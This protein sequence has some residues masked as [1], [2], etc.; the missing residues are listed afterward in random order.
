MDGPRC[1]RCGYD[2]EGLALDPRGRVTCP[3]CG[4]LWLPSFEYQR[5]RPARIRWLPL[6]VGGTPNALVLVLIL[7][8]TH[9]VW[10]TATP[11]FWATATPVS[12][13]CGAALG[14]LTSALL[15]SLED[16]GI[17][18]PFSWRTSLSRWFVAFIIIAAM[19]AAVAY[20]LGFLAT[21]LVY[22]PPPRPY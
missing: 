18:L 12:T 15:M 16:Q 3:E 11:D 13:L 14:G 19:V 7:G 2:L 8:G 10:G 5:H 20:P 21:M 4:A 1:L 9:G 22:D 17:D 6:I